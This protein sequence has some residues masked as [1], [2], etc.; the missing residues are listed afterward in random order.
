MELDQIAWNYLMGSPRDQAVQR[1]ALINAGAATIFL[2]LRAGLRTTQEF[3]PVR[4]R[5]DSTQNDRK[6]AKSVGYQVVTEPESVWIY[7]IAEPMLESIYAIVRAIGQPAYDALCRALWEQDERLKVLA[8]VVLMQERQPT[9]RTIK[10]VQEAF[11][12]IWLNDSNKKYFKQSFICIILSHFLARTG[13]SQHQQALR[14]G[15][16][17]LQVSEEHAI[18]MTRNAGL[19]YLI[20]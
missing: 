13:N 19:L 2:L 12:T 8:A 9:A 17:E 11:N 3:K 10:Q 7:Q 5:G 14:E 1:D 16:N 4:A 20:R 18:E 15:A 6:P